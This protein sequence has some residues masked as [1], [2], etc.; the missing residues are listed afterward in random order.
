M[1]DEKMT[2]EFRL[3]EAA[4]RLLAWYR[5][6]ARD[7]PWRHTRDPYHIWVSE[8]MLQQTRVAAVLGYYARFLEAFPTVDAL[9]GA[10]EDRLMKLWEGLGYYSRARNL[11]KTAKIVAEQGR[12]PE[13]YEELMKLPG[14]GDY[15]ASA[16]ASIAFGQR[17]PA[18]DGNVLR[19]VTRITDCHDDILDPKVKKK[20]RTRLQTVMPEAEAD[21][22]IFNQSVMELGA[23][24]CGPNGAPKCELCPVE[25][26]CLSRERG[27]SELLPVKKPKKARRKEEKT[28]FVL[29]R[30]GKTALRRRD[31]TGLLAGLW[32]FPHVEGALSEETAPECLAGWGLEP[33]NWHRKLTAKHIFTHVEWHMTGYTLEVSGDG[34]EEFLWVDAE[35]LKAHAVPSAFAR[36]YGE[37]LERLEKGT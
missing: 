32:E 17:E 3:N 5:K 6:N 27:T 18:V 20:I 16:V 9:A 30:E 34:P 23:I 29:L 36:Y 26:L 15:T 37:A 7:L 19:V 25:D 24:V 28:V 22:R 11:Q 10:P 2:T 14:V 1:K 4:Q 13:V 8:I 12:F 35:E 31:E 21:I 33:K